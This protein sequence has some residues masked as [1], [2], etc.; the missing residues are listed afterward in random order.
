M[1]DLLLVVHSSWCVLPLYALIMPLGSHCPAAVLKRAIRAGL[2][3]RQAAMMAKA[4]NL[5][6][7]EVER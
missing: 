5:Q 2:F 4:L 6:V 3:P 1:A 7:A